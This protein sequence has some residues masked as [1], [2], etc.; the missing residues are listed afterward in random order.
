MRAGGG[1]AP[2]ARFHLAPGTARASAIS[3]GD[4][5]GSSLLVIWMRFGCTR[6]RA[7]EHLRPRTRR[8]VLWGRG[9][10]GRGKDRGRA[11]SERATVGVGL[12]MSLIGQIIC[13]QRVRGGRVM[14]P[15]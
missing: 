3:K 13:V 10:A 2:A 15:R 4:L 7:R 8:F 9:Q 12:E 1:W 11:R 6:S 5:K 14:T